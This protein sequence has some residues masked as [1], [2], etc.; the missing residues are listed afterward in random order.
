MKLLLVGEK[1]NSSRKE[2][3]EAIEHS[4]ANKIQK[5]AKEQAQAGVNYIDVNAGLFLE[6]EPERLRWL[7][8]EIQKVVDLPC[9]LDSPN[10]AALEAALEVHQGKAMLNSISLEKERYRSLL[11]LIK[12]YGTKIVGLC[13][14]DEGMPKNCEDRFKIAS[15]L[16]ERL[17]RE[18]IQA[19]DIY[20][21]PLVQPIATN[22]LM[23]SVILDSIARFKAS[24]PTAHVIC[25]LSNISFGLPNRKLINQ[26]FLVLALSKGL[27]A[28][29]LDP[30][31]PKM[32]SCIRA[33]QLLLAQDE[34]CSEYL[35]AFRQGR[36]NY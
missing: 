14:N 29:V 2:I 23:G 18:G 11:P 12:K 20:L 15:D 33:A 24:F 17:I 21:D 19:D 7:V 8:K 4:D 25:G 30:T 1:I 3:K 9:C 28:V 13:L 22:H 16:T 10:P 5:I 26:I 27:D 6:Q 31:N 35:L 32:D 36:L 34:Y